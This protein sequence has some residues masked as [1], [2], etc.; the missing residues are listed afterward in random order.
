MY[1]HPKVGKQRIY[2]I[3]IG[4]DEGQLVK[5]VSHEPRHC[6]KENQYH[7]QNTGGVGQGVQRV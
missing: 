2:P 4:R 7:H 6:Q 3:A 5:R 1:E